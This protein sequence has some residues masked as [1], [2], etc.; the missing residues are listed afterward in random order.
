MRHR[1][2][3]AAVTGAALLGGFGVAAAHQV[4]SDPNIDHQPS[5]DSG[6]VTVTGGVFDGREFRGRGSR[7]AAA[8]ACLVWPDAG[9][10]AGTGV[11]C[12]RSEAAMERREAQL[13][14]QIA[15][16]SRQIANARNYRRPRPER[17]TSTENTHSYCS[18]G[19][20][21]Y[22]GSGF[23]QFLTR[24]R[25]RGHWVNLGSAFNDKTT[26]YKMVSCGGHLAE[27]HG[28][29]GFWCPCN[30]NAGGQDSNLTLYS[31][32]WANRISSVYLN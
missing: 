17:G 6:I 22:D 7:P 27:H 21:L 8:R 3:L 15:R 23:T 5:V 16:G 14:T 29:A 26:S 19:A 13:N 12:F 10:G 11:E 1:I 2:A 25:Q 9:I 30:T 32:S 28:G 18:N 20:D 24:I 31:P 4:D